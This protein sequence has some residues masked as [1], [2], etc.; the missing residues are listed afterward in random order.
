MFMCACSH[1][2]LIVQGYEH[3]NAYEYV[4]LIC[5]HFAFPTMLCIGITIF[6]VKNFSIILLKNKPL[7]NM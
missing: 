1:T 2:H 4:H 5:D 6:F 3:K 7:E